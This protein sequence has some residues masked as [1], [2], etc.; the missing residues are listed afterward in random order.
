MKRDQTKNLVTAGLFLAFGLI[1]PYVTSHMFGIQGTVLLPMHIPV[2]LCGLIC[3]PVYGALSSIMIPV[4][5]SLLTGMPAVYPML[6]IM[7]MQLL[8]FGLVSGLLYKKRELPIYPS[9]LLTMVSGWIVYGIMFSLLML[10]S[11]D[12]KALSVTAA[13]VQGIP[14]LV[15][16]LTLIPILVNAVSRYQ[17]NT[18]IQSSETKKDVAEAT[19][20]NAVKI[21]KEH[22]A[23]CVVIKDSSIVHMAEG[24]GVAPLLSLYTEQPE[25]LEGVVVIDKII[26]KAAAMILVQGEAAGAYGLVMSAAAKDYLDQYQIK[27]DYE[28]CVDMISNRD[29]TGICPIE[30]SVLEIENAEEGIEA[31]RATANELKRLQS[32]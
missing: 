29:Q 2:L 7:A 20:S 6:P 17:K 32:A 16:Q 4:M 11:G 12:I 8:T 24:K 5:S 21:I 10:V 22:R 28:L 27:A 14:G 15:V 26:G 13:L 25:K 18:N 3:G 9:L 23:S 31:I 30:R 1:L 19:I